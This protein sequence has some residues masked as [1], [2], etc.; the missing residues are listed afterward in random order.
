MEYKVPNPAGD[1]VTLFHPA[2]AVMIQMISLEM[3]E[4]AIARLSEMQEVVEPFFADIALHDTRKQGGQS[5]YGE[6]ET[7]GRGHG[8]ERQDIPQ[9]TTDVPAV[10]RSLM[11]FPMKRVE[12]LVK[13]AANQ[14]FAGRKAA[15]E[16]VTMKEIF[17][18]A[19]H[20]DAR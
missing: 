17:H 15:V 9:L 13:K 19:P 1:P 14:A 6:Q 7:Q 5:I 2:R 10:K 12:S 20:R 16:D 8:K 4:V 11:V 18:Q 3:P